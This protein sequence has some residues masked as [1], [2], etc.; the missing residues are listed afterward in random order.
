MIYI[1][2]KAGLEEIVTIPVRDADF[3]VI[4][5][6]EEIA[7]AKKGLKINL[8][9]GL[10]LEGPIVPSHTITAKICKHYSQEVSQM[11]RYMAE[12]FTRTI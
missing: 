6:V 11:D 10:Q 7:L 9:N 1:G 5:G 2:S 12:T 8:V 3:D 4:P